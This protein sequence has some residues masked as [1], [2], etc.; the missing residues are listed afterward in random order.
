VASAAAM[1]TRVMGRSFPEHLFSALLE[2]CYAAEPGAGSGWTMERE[3]SN[4]PAARAKDAIA[5]AAARV[6][7]ARPRFDLEPAA[8]E[9]AAIAERLPGLERTY[10]LLAD[11]RSRELLVRLL[12]FRALGPHHV[13]L[14]VRSAALADACARIDRE[15]R[16]GAAAVASPYGGEL[17]LYEL[18]GRSGPVRINAHPLTVHEFFELEQYAYRHGGA[19]AAPAP[20]DVAIDG[21][22]GWGDTALWLADAVGP[23]GRVICVEPEPGNREMIDANLA[24]NE[25]L[26]DRVETHASA[27]W[28][29]PGER[30]EFAAAGPSSSLVEPDRAGERVEVETDTVDAL[31]AHAGVDRLGF[32][33]LDVEGAELHALRG[34]QATLR[35][36]RPTLAIAAY[37]DPD[38]LVVLPAFVDD[39]GL[40]YRLYLDHFTPGREETILY[41][42]APGE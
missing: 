30:V 37:H 5:G 1:L 20:G 14:P 11:E 28:S 34:A 18:P 3:W 26:R 23:A 16:V 4:P 27:L 32:L 22:G 35:R 12:V 8:A 24:L 6:G 7:F 15:R 39:L 25:G 29:A 40:G 9:L 21:G 19:A 36:D 2:A 38:D 41:A 10:G 33:K 42:C 31:V 13:T 17:G